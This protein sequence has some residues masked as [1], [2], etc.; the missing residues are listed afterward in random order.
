MIVDPVQVKR[1]D[2]ASQRERIGKSV[3]GFLPYIF[4][5]MCF[6]GCMYPAL[7]LGAGEKERA[8]LETLLVAPVS[9]I[10]ILLG[11]CG[12]IV[13]SGFASIANSFIGF[14]VAVMLHREIVARIPRRATGHVRN[15]IHPPGPFSMLALNHLFCRHLN[16]YLHLCQ[17]VQRGA[18]H[19]G[20]PQ[21]HHYYSRTYRP[22]ARY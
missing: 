15:I 6:M 1:H 14:F 20:P 2:I 17:I 5:L 4:V 21:H 9:K 22:L 18:E 12:V 8:T 13:L 3:G 11:K 7:D 10:Q 19:Y 16:V